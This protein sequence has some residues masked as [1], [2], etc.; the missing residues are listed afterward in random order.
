MLTPAV[1]VRIAKFGDWAFAP[2]A[3]KRLN[4]IVRITALVLSY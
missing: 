4:A 3:I 1:M 2:K